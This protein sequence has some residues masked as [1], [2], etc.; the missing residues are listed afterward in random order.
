[1]IEK[2]T[3]KL[4]QFY[5][6]SF[7]FL[8]VVTLGTI[9]YFWKLGFVDGSRNKELHKANYIL[10]QYEVKKPLEEVQSIVL[11]EN[12]KLAIKKLDGL[13]NDLQKVSN[14]VEDTS[15]NDVKKEVTQIKTAIAN[16]ISFP[17]VDKIIGVF[18]D[19]MSKFNTYVKYNKW[20]TLT[21]TSQRILEVSKG[22]INKKKLSNFI[23]IVEKDLS[24]M[25]KV[26]EKSFLTRPQQS[27]VVS[28]IN[29]LKVETKML[30][31]YNEERLFFSGLMKD[32]NTS[33]NNWIT[34]ISPELSYQ[35]I[36]V[37]QM[38]RYYI[39]GLLGIL[40]LMSSIFFGGVAFTKWHKKKAAEDLEKFVED[41]VSDGLIGG[42]VQDLKTFS[43]RFQNF[44]DHTTEY[45]DKRMSYGAIFQEALPLSSIML[46][47]NLKVIWANK[48]FCDDWQVAEEEV[49]K[50]YLSWDYLSKLTNI[51]DN[52]PV[53]E[54][55]KHKVAGI[56]QIQIKPNNDAEV[57]PY[58]MFV[59]PVRY[60]QETR[61]MLFFYDLM[62]MQETI[63]SQARSIVTPIERILDTINQ[64]S[65]S[66]EEKEAYRKE[67]EIANISPL[68]DKFNHVVE[69]Q[70]SSKTQFVDQIEML[71]HKLDKT[72]EVTDDIERTNF[73]ISENNTSQVQNLKAFKKNV[74]ELSSFAKEFEQTTKEEF[75][76]LQN[77][78][79]AFA[80]NASK[81]SD[82]KEIVTQ[83]ATA[84]PKFGTIRE[85][86]KAQK[87]QMSE[88]KMRFSHSL[89]Q[90]VHLKKQIGE[91]ETLNR[92]NN[93]YDR[94]NSEF[95]KLDSISTD[96]EKRLT[97]LEVMLSKTQMLM[98]DIT[99][100]MPGFETSQENQALELATRQVNQYA[101]QINGL[102]G[103]ID[104][105]EDEIIANLKSLYIN[106]K[107]NIEKS[108]EVSAHL[109]ERPIL[110]ESF[111]ESEVEVEQN[112]DQID[113]DRPI[114]QQLS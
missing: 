54:A 68:L 48:Q 63:T 28:R 35:K 72:F 26:T 58:E 21:R 8:M 47:K 113:S 34:K 104:K 107:N 7:V 87:T 74:I 52:D 14:L 88:A 106:T 111:D 6:F 3:Q 45:I 97:N 33:V 55:L 41:F 105:T 114:D 73:E 16:L 10:E 38:G 46:D 83:L 94:V 43:K 18:N 64:G 96:L 89:A 95:K 92:F 1:M 12:S 40:A 62:N 9:F 85:D 19:K 76:T 15:F 109:S 91:G 29:N 24:Y 11:A 22:H 4:N 70:E 23:D 78:V 17:K 75:T 80:S 2:L 31:K 37:E 30:A 100:R 108:R 59:S 44:T 50:D 102:N 32:L 61:I 90:M 42:K 84:V 69:K 27:E 110:I 39:M 65:F 71:Y 112:Q 51:G 60:N 53:L 103:H 25:E 77:T 81:V 67:F 82:L 101:A 98:N 86:I 5:N 79:K 49:N 13:Q 56:Y 99:T 36:Q 66:E 93:S 20:R 57:R